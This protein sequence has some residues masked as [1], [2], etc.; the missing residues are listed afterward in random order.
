MRYPAGVLSRVGFETNIL[1]ELD[2]TDA[3]ECV[4]EGYGL[5]FGSTGKGVARL[6]WCD[7]WE[8]GRGEGSDKLKQR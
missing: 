4:R 7:G 3:D 2:L 1:L 8:E 5:A 6:V